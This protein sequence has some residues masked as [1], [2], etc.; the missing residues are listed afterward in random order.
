MAHSTK[1][2]KRIFS[3]F[4][5]SRLSLMS[6]VAVGALSVACN[7]SSTRATAS[8]DVG[9][10]GLML[11]VAPGTVL[12]SVGY[13]ITGP[14]SYVKTGTIDVSQTDV[15]SALL[16]PIPAGVGFTITL[17]AT[18]TGG[19]TCAGTA[20]FDVVAG[21]TSPVVVHLTC[22]EAAS[23]GSILVNGTLN[24]CPTIDG[25]SASAA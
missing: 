11:Q 25:I 23:T 22:H 10:V 20:S 8:Q 5:G 1:D 21:Q 17:N 16:S 6:A 12:S 9:A 24:V 14:A 2:R 19:T 18:A 15:I 4:L 7:G 3:L 13:T